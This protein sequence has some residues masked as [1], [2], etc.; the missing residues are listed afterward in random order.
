MA[1]VYRKYLKNQWAP[2]MGEDET[3]QMKG[4]P[5]P[6]VQKPFPEDAEL[7]D[8]VSPEQIRLGRMPLVEGR[9]FTN[10][11]INADFSRYSRCSF[12]GC[13]IVFEF[14]ICSFSYCDFDA[15]KF[16]A[17]TSSPAHLVLTLGLIRRTPLRLEIKKRRVV[18]DLE[19][20]SSNPA[21]HEGIN[22]PDLDFLNRVENKPRDEDEGT[23]DRHTQEENTKL[24]VKSININIPFLKI[25]YYNVLGR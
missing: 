6:P 11:Y 1:R 17:K 2:G 4:L 13:T 24:K 9:I 18:V 21:M 22:N 16:E 23:S 19:Q 12:H 20:N 14:G 8:L 3:D 25:V 15:C 5:I 10:E 7:V